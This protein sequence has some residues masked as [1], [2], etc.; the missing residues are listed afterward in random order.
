MVSLEKA[1]YTTVD[2]SNFFFFNE[3]KNVC[4]LVESVYRPELS[5][6][7]GERSTNRSLLEMAIANQSTQ[8]DRK[9]LIDFDQRRWQEKLTL[10]NP[11]LFSYFWRNHWWMFSI[12]FII[13]TDIE[14]KWFVDR[15]SSCFFP[16]LIGNS[17]LNVQPLIIN[18]YRKRSKENP[19]PS[20][21][22]NDEF[23]SH[24]E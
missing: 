6:E 5:N 7:N 4:K 20:F 15:F 18:N 10:P 23:F 13:M 17:W 22:K 12:N 11:N 9:C 19:H 24:K 3:T 2:F 1:L 16:R 21:W 8:H 14:G